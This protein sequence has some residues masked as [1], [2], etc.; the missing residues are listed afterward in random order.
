MPR[1]VDRVAAEYHLD[2]DVVVDLQVVT[3]EILTNIVDYGYSDDEEHEITI[4]FRVLGNM[5]EAVF[6]DDGVPFDPLASSAPD[7][8]APLKK[9]RA[10]GLGLHFVRSL[11]DE[12]SYH[13]T[14]GRNRLVLK[15][16]L[17][18]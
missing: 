12:V 3:D 14:G 18:K 10:G 5:L 7:I 9:R 15:R 2:Q 16:K 11:M 1:F 4:R 6:E 17:K 13:R 8:S